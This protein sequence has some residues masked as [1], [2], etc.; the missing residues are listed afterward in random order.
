MARAAGMKSYLAAVSDRSQRVFF[1]SYLSLTQL[2]DDLAIVNLDGKDRF[3]DPGSKFCPFGHLLWKHTMSAGVRQIDGGS[4]ITQT[5]S[6]K[7][8]ESRIQRV[9]NLTLDKQ[10]IASGTIR[11]TYIGAPALQW[12]QASLEGDDESLKRDLRTSME[13]LL[14]HGMEVKVASID[15]L[16]DYEQPL[17]V[18]YDVKGSLGSATGKRLIL[19]GDLFEAN[20]KATF[21]HERREVGV[22]FPYTHMQQD[23]I[24]VNFPKDF[25]VESLPTGGKLQLQTFAVYNLSA[26]NAPTSFTIRR[27]YTLGEVIFM[28][29]EYPELR[30]FYSG[31]ETRDQQNVILKVQ[32]PLEAKASPAA[33]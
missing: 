15:Q 28:P 3:F 21:P 7:Y 33:N 32:P 17:S 18:L 25:T 27:N 6:E 5:P 8:T 26:E 1:P 24:R 13:A 10:G 16:A 19:P 31:M 11:I 14:P 12:R 29:K 4:A 30:T 23:A 9:A 2:D 22:Y 20:S